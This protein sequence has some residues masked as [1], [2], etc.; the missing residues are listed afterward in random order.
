MRYTPDPVK[1]AALQSTFVDMAAQPWRFDYFHALRMIEAQ[2]PH[3]PRLGTARRPVDEPVRL[4]QNPELSFAPAALHAVQPA[5][6]T[7]PPRIE[8]R[9]FGLFGPNGPLPLHLTEY[10]RERLLHQNDP[11]FARFAD[12]FHHRL[13]LLFYRAW[14]QAQPTVAL[15]RPDEDRFADYTGSLG[16]IGSLTLRGR[17]AAPDHAKLFFAGLLARQVRN[18]DG[19]AALLSGYLRRPVEVEQFVGAWMPLPE[20]ERTR[21]GLSIAGRTNPTARLGAGAVLGRTVW[22]RQCNFRIHIGPLDAEAFKS[23]LPDG[24]A[25]PAVTALV[26][27]YATGELAWD[28]KLTLRADHVAP[29]RLGRAGRLGW[30]SWVGERR[31]DAPAELQLSPASALKAMARRH[32][33]SA[34]PAHAVANH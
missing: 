3:K 33:S 23:L 14:A 15:D 10:A 9:F 31:K 21:I 27:H 4:G 29:V 6:A 22:D 2:H 11:T 12:L 32:R 34:T 28:L 20:A 13:L 16:G 30:T 25:L 7:R 26:A 18:A 1:L 24:S 17:D 8:V 5:S 19:L